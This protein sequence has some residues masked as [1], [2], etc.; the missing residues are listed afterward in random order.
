M[1][2]VLFSTGGGIIEQLFQSQFQM[3]ETHRL[4]I[5]SS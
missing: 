5:V 2:K 1:E 4:K 3:R